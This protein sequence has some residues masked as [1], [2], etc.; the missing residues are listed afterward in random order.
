MTLAATSLL[1]Q[2]SLDAP[3]ELTEAFSR[4]PRWRPADVNRGADMIVERLKALGVPVTV[5]EPEIYLSIPFEAAVK[6]VSGVYRAGL[7][8]LKTKVESGS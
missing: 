7:D 4:Q 8:A 5:H 6:A 3:W 2:V 1:E